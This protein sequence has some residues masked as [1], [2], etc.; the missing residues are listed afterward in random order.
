PDGFVCIEKGTAVDCCGNDIVVR[1][2]DCLD[3]LSLPEIKAAKE[4]DPGAEHV[5]Q[6]CIRY[7]EC[8]TEEIPVLYDE[9]GCDDSRCAPNRILE[10]YELGVILDPA[11]VTPAPLPSPCSDLW[12]KSIDGCPHCDMPDC[13]VLATIKHYHVGDTIKN[14]APNA[15]YPINDPDVIDNRTDR[16]L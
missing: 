7:R 10:C 16:H 8:A 15:T 5:L 4:K 13:I 14:P 9:C 6:I 12:F 1:E 3:L 11:P 2:T